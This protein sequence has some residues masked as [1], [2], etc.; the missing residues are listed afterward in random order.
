MGGEALV[1]E[2]DPYGRRALGGGNLNPH[3]LVRLPSRHQGL[4]L[5]HKNKSA[6]RCLSFSTESFRLSRNDSVE[7][8]FL[9]SPV[10]SPLDF[11]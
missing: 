6:R 4:V 1:G 2:A 8:L 11:M 10:V 3:R 9:M 7:E 5:L